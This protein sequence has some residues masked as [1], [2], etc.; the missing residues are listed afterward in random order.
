MRG[1]RIGEQRRSEGAFST[2]SDDDGYDADDAN[3]RDD[4][5]TE[6]IAAAIRAA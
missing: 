6:A 1:I 3:H 2:A 4:R 5:P